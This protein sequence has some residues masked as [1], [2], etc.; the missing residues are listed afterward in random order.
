LRW[1]SLTVIL[2][3]SVIVITGASSGM[4]KEL[5]FRYS[6]RGCK[7]VIGSRNIEKL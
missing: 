3:N 5:A 6:A 1:K 4:G 2:A 7:V